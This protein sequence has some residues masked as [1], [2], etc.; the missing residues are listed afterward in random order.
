[1]AGEESP[2]S[3]RLGGVIV[4]AVAAVLIAGFLV[5][6]LPGGDDDE[7]GESAAAAPTATPTASPAQAGNDIALQGVGGSD[8]AGVMR[9]FQRDDGTVQFA[10]AAEKVPANEGQEVYAVWFTKRSGEARRLGFAQSQVGE[11]GVLTTGGPTEADLRR[12]PRWFATY[13]FVLV[14]RETAAD[15]K[16]PGRAVLRGTLP[17]GAG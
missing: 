4:L 5:W 12:F 14:T 7:G 6:Y 17:S 8:A 9:L 10:L 13:D 3:S 16:K 11:N 2:R 1:V 15:A